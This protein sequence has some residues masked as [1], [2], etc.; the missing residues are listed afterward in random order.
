MD[1]E[2][3]EIQQDLKN[4]YAAPADVGDP[5]QPME[6]RLGWRGGWQLVLRIILGSAMVIYVII[7][8]LSEMMSDAESWDRPLGSLSL[9]LPVI[10]LPA[11]AI[12]VRSLHYLP[13]PSIPKTIVMVIM[14]SLV[15]YF[16][17]VPVCFVAT[18]MSLAATSEYQGTAM[19]FAFGISFVVSA[20]IVAWLMRTW[21]MRAWM[22]RR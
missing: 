9:L 22:S 21:M 17:Y 14:S 6:D 11:I 20:L 18:L 13:R 12:F 3:P 10:L 7:P 2:S 15:G 4:A 16:L 1:D 19:Y 5:P 8:I